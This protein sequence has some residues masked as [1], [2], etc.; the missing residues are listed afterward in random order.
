MPNSVVNTVITLDGKKKSTDYF[1][2]VLSHQYGKVMTYN[3]FTLIIQ[4]LSY[5]EN[6][7]IKPSLI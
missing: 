3:N 1:K 5:K 6:K 7:L 4:N 2:T